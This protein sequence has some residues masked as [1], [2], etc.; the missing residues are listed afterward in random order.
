MAENLNSVLAPHRASHRGLPDNLLAVF[1]IYRNHR[2]FPRGKR[3]G[4]SPNELLG[5]PSAHWLDVLGYGHPKAPI[6]GE[7]PTL[8]TPTV[9]TLAA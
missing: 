5:L 8:P 1:R 3:A 6:A 9:N 2:V 7:L 4:Y